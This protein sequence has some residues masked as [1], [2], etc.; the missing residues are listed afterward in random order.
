M[1][2]KYPLFLV[3][4]F[5]FL[6]YSCEKEFNTKYSNSIVGK[7]RWIKTM[8]VIPFSDINPETPQNT[9]IEEL[10]TFGADFEWYKTQNNIL[11]DSG[12]Y[13]IG[14]GSYINPSNVTY[15]YDSI[16]YYQNNIPI[17]NGFDFY[18]ID[19]D[20]LVF[21]SAFGARWWSFTLSHAGTKRWVRVE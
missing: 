18:E 20:T 16:C 1:K 4:I 14:H 3:T 19:H 15:I 11:V 6:F 2:K 5:V 12:S 7:W 17:K 9:G 21:C 13:T 10:L 8:R